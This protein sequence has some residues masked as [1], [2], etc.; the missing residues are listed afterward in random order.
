MTPLVELRR[1]WS[2]P[3]DVLGS[4]FIQ[5]LMQSHWLE[6]H[7]MHDLMWLLLF[8]HVLIQFRLPIVDWMPR[9]ENA[10]IFICLL[11]CYFRGVCES[12][13]CF[14]ERASTFVFFSSQKVHFSKL[15]QY[16]LT[17]KWALF[18]KQFTERAGFLA[19]MRITTEHSDLKRQT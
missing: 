2:L 18:I 12:H 16:F 13:S 6:V 1:S 14:E 15:M 9:K 11:C 19:E 4:T 17:D 8:V 7:Y 5:S 3:E 10:Y